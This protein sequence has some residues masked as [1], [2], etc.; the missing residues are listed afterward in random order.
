MV[1]KLLPL[2]LYN[3]TNW[4]IDCRRT[5]LCNSFVDSTICGALIAAAQAFAIERLISVQEQEY[6]CIKLLR[7]EL[8]EEAL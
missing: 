8:P 6:S 3:I 5:W 4:L 2:R 7:F 1:L